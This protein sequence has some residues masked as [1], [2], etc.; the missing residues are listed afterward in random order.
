MRRKTESIFEEF[1]LTH[2]VAASVDIPNSPSHF[3]VDLI[4]DF[5][6]NEW[7][8]G[9]IIP[10]ESE[11]QR[12][13]KSPIQASLKSALPKKLPILLGIRS[14]NVPILRGK[15]AALSAVSS[16]LCI[17]HYQTK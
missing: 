4:D 9:G 12:Y 6:I 17:C 14:Q 10:K 16:L 1:R 2:D 15:R 5:D 3:N 7:R 8:F 13:L 11:L